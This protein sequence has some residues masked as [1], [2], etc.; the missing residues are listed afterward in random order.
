MDRFQFPAWLDRARPLF[1]AAIVLVPVYLVGVLY[2]GGS[3]QTT[4]VGYAPEQPV[5]YSHA[6]HVG[7]LGMDCRFCHI[8]A[9]TSAHVM[10]PSTQVCMTCHARAATDPKVN[11][12]LNLVNESATTGKAI[13]WVRVHDL[14]DYVY[15]DHSAHVSRGVGCV[16]CHGRVDRMERVE[17]VQ[18]LSMGWC[19]DCHRNPDAHLRPQ[20][21]LTQMDW[22]PEGPLEGSRLRKEKN[23]NPSTDCS[24]CHR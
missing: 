23:I 18:P 9:E 3:P 15:F 17:Q 16:E 1:G 7:Q 8:N 21:A 14:P 10:I 19:L 24:T 11:R 12:R 5:P 13:P 20:S 2:Y 6:V 22:T 4:D